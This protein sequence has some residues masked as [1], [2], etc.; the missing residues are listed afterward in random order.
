MC[1][2]GLG[3]GY[4]SL[5]LGCVFDWGFVCLGL[6]VG[7]WWVWIG[8]GGGVWCFLGWVWGVGFCCLG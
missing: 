6:V 4:S 7:G 1:F 5:G 8:V 2:I 3:I